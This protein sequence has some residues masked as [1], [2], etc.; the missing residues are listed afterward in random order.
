MV[1]SRKKSESTKHTAAAT[2]KNAPFPIVGLG[3]SAGGLAAFEAFFSGIPADADPGM[4]FV[5]V[6][7]LAPD[8]KSL[9]ADLVRR[10]TRMQVEEV[11]DGM[12]VKVNCAYIIPP[13]RDMA[14]LGGVLHLMEP[15]SPRGQRMPIDFF[16]RS[17]AQDLHE[18][19]ICVVLSGTGTDGSLGVRA[20][21]GEGGMAMVQ[22]PETTEY[23]GMPLSAIATGL[24]DF[25]LAP[26]EMPATIRAYVSHAFSE[27]NKS[28]LAVPA[29]PGSTM[30]K[31]LILLRAGSGHDFSKYKTSTVERRIRRRMAVQQLVSMDE[32]LRYVQQSQSELDALFN[33]LLIGVTSFFRD[34]EA[35]SALEELVIPQLLPDEVAESVIRVWVPACSTGE[36]AFSIAMLLA[37]Y[38]HEKKCSLPVQIFATDID[39]RAIAVARKGI[40]PV[41]IAADLSRE[42]L[43]RF[44]I[45]EPDGTSYRIHRNIRDMV[46]FSE[47]D[48]IKDPPFSRIDLISCRNMLIYMNAEL[49]KKL[50]PLFHYSLNPGGFLFL[51]SSETIGDFDELYTVKDRKLKIYQRKEPVPGRSGLEGGR[52]P[53]SGSISGLTT[54]AVNQAG[55]QAG[56]VSG[57]PGT[58]LTMKGGGSSSLRELTE[59]AMLQYLAPAG[60]LVDG[61]GDILYLLGRTGSYLEPAPGQAGVNNILRMAREGL[62]QILTSGLRKAMLSRK[63]VTYPRLRVRT[64]GDFSL[65]NLTIR[66]LLR[67]TGSAMEMPLYLVIFEDEPSSDEASDSDSARAFPDA[68]PSSLLVGNDPDDKAVIT[69]LRDELQAKEEYLQASR[70]E[71]QSSNEELK[72]SNEEMQS[73]NEELQSTNEELETSKEE[74]QSANEE[75]TTINAELQTKLADLSRVN[76]DMNNLLAGTDIGTIFVDH[77]LCILR[78]TP[79]ATRIINLIQSDVGRPMGH[80][81]SRLKEYDNLLSDTRIVLDTLIPKEVEVQT[82]DGAW[83]LMR[84]LPYRTLEN[85]IEGAVLTFVETSATKAAQEALRLAEMRIVEAEAR[86]HMAEAVVATVREPLVLLDADLR[87]VM[88]N[89]AFYSFFR[90]VPESATGELLYDLGQRQWDNPELRR[91]LGQILPRDEVLEN[92]E[93]HTS[94]EGAGQRTM[95]L[96]A[97]RVAGREGKTEFILLAFEDVTNRE[98]GMKEGTA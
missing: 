13:N 44:F 1:L 33:D 89:Q 27:Q 5:L 98:P 53:Y 77:R 40:Y 30:K 9:L 6:Q 36:E 97:R 88:A 66:P 65:V 58:R 70:E 51:G 76:N 72:S 54:L 63:P 2:D 85:V 55:T 38:Q 93:I 31:I 84:I 18:R 82:I 14:L 69:A 57:S 39:A 29:E 73:I 19:A 87:V 24:V 68:N 7:H 74:L 96:N 92:Y 26:A 80:I 32:Y 59:Q 78:F 8:H 10:Y 49:Q 28:H 11:E 34:S 50:I 15:V 3:A 37:E 45:P 86:Q 47:Q 75:L 67:N 46:V 64:N 62:Q 79:A 20:V 95:W 23:D 83:F 48:V 81:V 61:S 22:K 52:S 41:S 25:A 12:P 71:L 16:F 56:Q 91:L 35:F 42:R 17:L 94:I 4:S 43:A 60:A 90:L 21:K